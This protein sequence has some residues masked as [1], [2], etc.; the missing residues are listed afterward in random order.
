M[1]P[2]GRSATGQLYIS[3]VL[4]NIFLPCSDTSYEAV[5]RGDVKP[6]SHVQQMPLQMRPQTSPC[7]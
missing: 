1:S 5:N 4:L 7:G 2:L 3:I 6:T